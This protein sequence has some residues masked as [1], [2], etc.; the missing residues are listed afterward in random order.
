MILPNYLSYLFF[1]FVYIYRMPQSQTT[2][3]KLLLE[4][5]EELK[6][7]KQQISVMKVEV[8]Y[9]TNKLKGDEESRKGWIW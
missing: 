3:H 2:N 8:N 5:L 4:L 9:I 6:V 1:T 7:L